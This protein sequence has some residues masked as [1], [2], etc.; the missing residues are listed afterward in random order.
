[1]LEPVSQGIARRRI[2]TL[3]RRIDWLT[4]K[5]E[6]KSGRDASFFLSERT[7]T[8]W[9]VDELVALYVDHD[10]NSQERQKT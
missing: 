2:Q 5:A 7:A 4:A 9:A 1:M 10:R 8:Q 3:R 6:G